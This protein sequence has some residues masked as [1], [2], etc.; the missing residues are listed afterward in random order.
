MLISEQLSEFTGALCGDGC[1]SQYFVKS[2][3]R[4]RY[5]IAFTGS[6]DD[7]CYYNDFIQPTIKT[8]F[9]FNGRL[10]LRGNSTRF[11]IKSKQVFNFF[12]CLGLPIG[13]KGKTLAM[14]SIIFSNRKNALAFVS[15]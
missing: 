8:T 15:S 6:T 10:F 13:K 3:G 7:F 1:L 5:E 14:P 9:G 4:V 2:E 12:K 11:H